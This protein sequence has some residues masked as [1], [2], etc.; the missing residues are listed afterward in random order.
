MCFVPAGM[1]R[2]PMEML[3]KHAEMGKIICCGVE[4]GTGLSPRITLG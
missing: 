3:T 1:G 4:M 2:E